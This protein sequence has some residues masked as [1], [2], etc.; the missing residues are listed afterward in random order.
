MYIHFVVNTIRR[1]C[2][3]IFDSILRARRNQKDDDEIDLGDFATLRLWVLV[4][5]AVEQVPQELV[6]SFPTLAGDCAAD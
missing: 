1:S 5:G 4:V 6:E 3:E 2:W